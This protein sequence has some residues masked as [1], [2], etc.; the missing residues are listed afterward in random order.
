MSGRTTTTSLTTNLTIR[1]SELTHWRS[2]MPRTQVRPDQL[3]L[4]RHEDVA[5]AV[6]AAL[7]DPDPVNR[8]EAA[9][10]LMRWNLPV[11]PR[12]IVVAAQRALDAQ[13]A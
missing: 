5:R 2:R 10:L 7:H 13:P 8:A 4:P 11:A 1:T 12:A 9:A 6:R 3:M